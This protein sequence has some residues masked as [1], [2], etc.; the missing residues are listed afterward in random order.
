M[1]YSFATGAGGQETLRKRPD[2]QE[3]DGGEQARR[4]G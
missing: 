1:L 4:Q 2:F 3:N